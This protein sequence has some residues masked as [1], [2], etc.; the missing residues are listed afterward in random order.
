MH[1]LVGYF[2]TVNVLEVIQ[3]G[4]EIG[5]IVTQALFLYRIINMQ[6]TC[7]NAKSFLSIQSL[8]YVTSKVITLFATFS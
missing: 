1:K 3:D 5:F 7:L 2:P 4:L 6:N 8:L